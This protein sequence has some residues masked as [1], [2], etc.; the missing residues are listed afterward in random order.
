MHI[1]TIIGA[2]ALAVFA[3]IVYMRKI[4]KTVRQD[5]Y[6]SPTFLDHEIVSFRTE[7]A[8]GFALGLSLALLNNVLPLWASLAVFLAAV[9]PS[10]ELVRRRHNRRVESP[11]TPDGDSGAP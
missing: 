9:L 4:S 8:Y 5:R 1:V 11:T 3:S 2:A 10:T 6:I 7:L